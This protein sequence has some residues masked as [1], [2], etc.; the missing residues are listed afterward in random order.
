MAES[1]GEYN[2]EAERQKLKLSPVSTCI[3]LFKTTIGVG[4]FTYQ[5][6]YSKVASHD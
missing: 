1:Q 4:I 2:Y 6:A 5:Y 3:L